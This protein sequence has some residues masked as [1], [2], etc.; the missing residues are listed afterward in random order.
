MCKHVAAA[1]YGIGARLDEKPDLL[2]TLR[3]VDE[4]ELIAKAGK[5]LSIAQA[6][7]STERVIA[8]DDI[9]ALFGLD[10][11]E[12]GQATLNVPSPVSPTAT[13]R[14]GASKIMPKRKKKAVAKKRSADKVAPVALST[15]KAS[16]KIA[17]PKSKIGTSRRQSASSPALQQKGTRT[18][19]RATK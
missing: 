12:G 16:S 17:A 2:F 7:Q 1:M 3:A 18:K 4:K 9:S 10:M 19:K 8:N 14:R 13:S 5:N 11:D 15:R 6:T